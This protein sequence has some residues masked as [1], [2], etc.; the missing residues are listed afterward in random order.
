M[1]IPTHL[2]HPGFKSSSRRKTPF[3]KTRVSRRPPLVP[4]TKQKRPCLFWPPAGAGA[5][6]VE[7]S[8]GKLEHQSLRKLRFVLQGE[9]ALS[10]PLP[11][12]G[13]Q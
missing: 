10:E 13:G 4:K 7:K 6:A 5:R 9:D 8:G 12:A 3:A 2:W 11:S 1:P